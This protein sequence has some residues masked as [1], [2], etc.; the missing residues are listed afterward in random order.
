MKSAKLIKSPL[1]YPGGKSRAVK[2]LYKYIPPGTKT[3]SSPFFGGGS[4]EIY[5]AQQGIKVI[6]YD[7]FESLV[8][9]WQELL[10]N[11]KK[12]ADKVATYKP[13]KFSKDQF[14]D[15]QK[16]HLDTTDPFM[17]AVE[18]Y[19]LNRTSFSGSTLS[20]GMANYKG[21]NPRF[22]DSSVERIRNFKIENI[23]SVKVKDFRKSINLKK[24]KND[25]LYLDPPYL[26]ENNLYG[27]RGDLQK[28]FD[29]DALLIELKKRESWILSYNDSDVIRS[30][31][32]EFQFAEPE[33]SYG[34]S[35]NKK[36]KEILILSNDLP[37]PKSKK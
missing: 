27:N 17:S 32:E 26:I 28:D 10:K 31:Y 7:A 9:F 2:T 15:L 21:I 35:K 19:V 3:L 11:P 25:L 16:S 14:Y 34:M 29:H 24:H 36:S 20:G 22:T 23:I 33:W 18:F 5:C 4:F 37:L 1:R 6:G 13:G 12:L 8:F 30:M